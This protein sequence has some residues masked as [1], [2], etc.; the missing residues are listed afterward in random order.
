VQR[1]GLLFVFALALLARVGLVLA[2]DPPLLYTHQNNYYSNGLRIAEHQDPLGFVLSSDRWR[3][4]VAGTTIAP[5]YYLLLGSF[6][7]VFGPGLLPLRVFQSTL[8]ALVAVAAASLGRRL[9]G[10]IGLLA[11][12]AYALHW[13]GAEM[14]CWTMTE[15]L[16]T[17]LLAGSFALVAREATNGRSGTTTFLAGL[18][19]GLSG[20]TRSVSSAFVPLAPFWRALRD[21]PSPSAVRRQLV[22]AALLLAGGL[23]CVFLWSVRNRML[24]DKVPIETVGFFNLWDD[25]T[26]PLVPEPE[27]QRQLKALQAT[28]T[29]SDYG[30]LA[31]ALT[32][33]NILENPL[34]FARKI[35]LNFWH[36]VRPEGLHNLLLR[37]YPDPLWRQLGIIVFDDLV[38][39][40]TVPLFGAFLLGGPPSPTRR[41]IALW[42]VYYLFMVT[43]VFHSEA[44]YR[45]ALMPMALPGA[46]AGLLAL[47]PRQP[48]R[49]RTLAL[50][51]LTLGA[52]VSLG[53]IARYVAPAVRAVRS[54]WAMGAALD[55]LEKGDPTA[56]RAAVVAAASHDPDAARPWR[57]FGRWLAARDL[58]EPAAAAYEQATRGRWA[59]EWPSAAVRPS[60]LLRAGHDSEAQAA[61]PVTHRLS[62][63]V[64]PWLL[65]EV[66]WQELPAPR[67]DEVRLGSFDYGAVR[68]F[69]HPR[70]IDPDLT[71]HRREVRRYVAG[72]GPVPPPGLHRWSRGTAWLRLR[73]L[74]AARSYAVVLT[75]GSP[76][77]SRLD[78]PEVEV[79]IGDG[80]GQRMKLDPELRDYRFEG[81]AG[82]DG[83]VL[84]RLDAP[85]WARTGE[86][87]DQG[88]RVDA[89]R[90]E[91]LEP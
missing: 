83:V 19:L 61:L 20:L 15:N 13:P 42:T 26:R 52:L 59:I 30:N 31:L 74:R 77:P 4:W 51:G 57:T 47:R 18:L 46:V 40:L 62:W 54:T 56:A 41:L 33:R 23:S 81:K 50:V 73:P 80:P 79:R 71:R 68:G 84:V 1:R 85:T 27:R 3:Q 66:A 5:L 70:G 25:N 91:S 22:P 44:R 65:L 39:L 63:D 55:A 6:F 35:V 58:A 78:N 37:E 32:A 8:D 14:V 9:A 88:V 49:G 34:G 12:V 17:V 36:F 28:P 29:P 43:V 2:W 69:Y 53:A 38:L 10:P 7:K 72:E 48:N 75:M 16:H 87:A 90:V 45:S 60:L 21:G 86:P 82:P 11:G 67:T 89:M 64:D 76:F 24:G